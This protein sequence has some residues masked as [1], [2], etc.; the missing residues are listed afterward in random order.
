[1]YSK[2]AHIRSE[3][4]YK[5]DNLSSQLKELEK[6]DK[7]NSKASRIQAITK[8]K[9]ELKETETQK[10]PLKKSINPGAGF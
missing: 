6:Q 10:K 9:A 7:T 3:K 5:A 8:I 2:N 4:R 1:M